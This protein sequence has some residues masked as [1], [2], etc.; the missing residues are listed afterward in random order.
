ME[1][2][3]SPSYSA[4]SGSQC[5]RVRVLRLH[6]LHHQSY[7][8][9]SSQYAN[10]K[11]PSDL[12]SVLA[13]EAFS[14][15]VTFAITIMPSRP[16]PMHCHIIYTTSRRCLYWTARDD[17][18]SRKFIWQHA[19]LVA[20]CIYLVLPSGWFAFGIHRH[21]EAITQ[22]L[23]KWTDITSITRR[24]TFKGPISSRHNGQCRRRSLDTR[25]L[26]PVYNICTYS[27]HCTWPDPFVSITVLFRIVAIGWTGI[28]WSID[29]TRRRKSQ[30]EIQ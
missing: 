12:S 25:M 20:R 6:I 17:C 1:A 7:L 2:C 9:P 28:G 14:T 4:I 21:F 29:L 30:E 13:I 5:L 27:T 3:P 26:Y 18:S 23:V 19:Q 11:T 22:L 8:P 10:K 24:N 15:G 16:P